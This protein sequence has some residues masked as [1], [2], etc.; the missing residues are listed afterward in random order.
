MKQII[1]EK[2]FSSKVVS[3]PKGISNFIKEIKKNGSFFI[4]LSPGFVLIFLLAYVPIPG[5]LMAFEKYQFISKNFFVN[6]L[7]CPWVWFNNFWIFFND[8]NFTKALYNTV[9]YHLFF[10]ISGTVISL[11]IALVI[12][13]MTNRKMAKFYHSCMLLPY[14]LSWIV[15]SYV[16]FAFLGLENGF[17]NNSIL[18]P[19]G[20]KEISFYSEPKYWTFILFLVNTIKGAAYSS[21]LYLSA[22]VGLD[23]E[24][25]ELARIYGASKWQQITQIT[26]PLISNII[27]ILLILSLGNILSVDFG[28]FYNVPLRSAY[29]R[30]ATKTIDIYVYDLMNTGMDGMAKSTAANLFKSVIGMVMVLS[31]NW[32]VKRIDEEKALF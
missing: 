5:I 11:A 15:F 21:I 32:V 9:F 6:L 8:I 30:D 23:P 22:I 26:L 29:L 18:V 20:L 27:I 2:G 12:H 16:V 28:L 24:Y 3:K 14:F 1:C 31:T 19:M 25:F 4:L 10:M 17:I 13:E 7:K